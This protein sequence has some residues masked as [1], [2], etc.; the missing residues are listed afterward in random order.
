MQAT[1]TRQRTVLLL[2]ESPYFGGITSHILSILKAFSKEDAFRF[3]VATLPGRRD[4][5]TLIEA[6]EAMGHRVHVLPMS[7]PY[8]LRV[9]GA[10]RRLVAD[11]H[12]DLIHTHNY[13]ATLVCARL[14]AEIPVINTCHGQ[15]VAPSLR[16]LLWQWAELRAM[17]RHRLTVACSEHVR[18]WLTKRGLAPDKIRA[19]YNGYELPEGEASLA[20]DAFDIDEGKCVALFVGRLV[21]GKG[22]E[23]LIR[24]VAGL[25][26]WTAL[27]AGDGP[28]RASLESEAAALGADVRFVGRVS[29]PGPYY[30]LADVVVLPSEMEALPMTLIEAAAH[31]VP[32]VATRVGG[33]TEVVRDGSSGI[34]VEPGGSDALRAALARLEDN[35]IRAKMGRCAKETWRA[36]FTL[37]RMAR[38]LV[39]VYEDC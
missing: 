36:R 32:A 13:R 29:E 37:E 24:A 20:R 39:R 2:A 28:I 30:G 7:W 23:A 4:D 19:V 12:I 1:G 5:V 8:D 3:V 11:E 10:L 9:V 14:T 33:M 31:G 18:N 26:H 27:I 15:K 34:L 6:V 35:T 25:T 17:R 38:K 21:E 22:V 16:M